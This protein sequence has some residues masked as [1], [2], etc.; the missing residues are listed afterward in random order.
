[1]GLVS[2]KKKNLLFFIRHSWENRQATD[3]EKI[4]AE[5]TS[6]RG[7]AARICME[8]C[9]SVWRRQPIFKKRQKI[10]KALSPKKI[11]MPG[12]TKEDAHYHSSSWQC[13]LNCSCYHY[14]SVSRA[15][16]ATNHTTCW[17]ECRETITLAYCWWE[18][19]NDTAA[20][21]DSLKVSHKI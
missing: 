17:W 21:E 4:F 20:L 9:N 14:A 11:W 19:K 13:R 10:W 16:L 8:P 18:C 7:L 1:M 5:H 6:D 12:S 15:N 2:F 3:W